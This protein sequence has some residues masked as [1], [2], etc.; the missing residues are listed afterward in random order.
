LDIEIP[1]YAPTPTVMIE[2]STAR[3]ARVFVNGQLFV[4]ILGVS[5]ADGMRVVPNIKRI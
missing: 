2:G 4:V 5:L 3:G 1:K